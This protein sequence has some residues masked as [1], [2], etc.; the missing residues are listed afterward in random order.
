M[1]CTSIFLASLLV[2]CGSLRTSKADEPAR[3]RIT[4]GQVAAGTASLSD[5]TPAPSPAIAYDATTLDSI[6]DKPDFPWY[7]KVEAV[8]LRRTPLNNQIIVV[9]DPSAGTNPVAV[10]VARLDAN[11]ISFNNNA[12]PGLGLTLG[13]QIDNV[14]AVEISY[15]GLYN[16]TSGAVVNGANSLSLPGTIAITTQDFF[17]ADEVAVSYES[18]LNNMEINYKQTINGLSLL[19]GFRYINIDE[20]FN[21]RFHDVDTGT[22]N[23]VIHTANN[24]I[25]GQVGLGW[26]WGVGDRLEA[27]WFSKVG[28]FGNAQYM[29]QWMADFGNLLPR[30]D[31]TDHSTH[32]AFVAEV[33]VNVRL[34]VTEWMTILGGYRF[35]WLDGLALAPQ[36]VDF[37]DAPGAG[38]TFNSQNGNFK[39]YGPSAG[40][41][42]RW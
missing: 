34:R 38:Q 2:I 18:H 32:T 5:A 11:E 30:R 17:L 28:V 19:G 1:R 36:Q 6:F 4:D 23:Y 40:V 8:L 35:I 12:Q 33:G 25:G 37:N 13:R 7:T 15:F 26:H 22:S 14:S 27:D 31:F 29:N 39:L 20:E 9:E 16:W 3:L 24:L 41:E 42:F 21:M 10:S